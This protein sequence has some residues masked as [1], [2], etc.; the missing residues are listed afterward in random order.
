MIL[1]DCSTVGSP[2]FIHVNV[3]GGEPDEVQDNV[4]L[5]VAL[6]PSRTVIDDGE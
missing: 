5:L 3:S 4:T 1:L 6:Y 2:S